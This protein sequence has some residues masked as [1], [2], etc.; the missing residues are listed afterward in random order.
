MP[1]L[2]FNQP[3][4]TA[5]RLAPIG[6]SLD[7]CRSVRAAFGGTVNDVLVAAVAGGVRRLLDARGEC[8]P[9]A[10]VTVMCPVSH[11]EA[12]DAS[13]GNQATGM[14]V[15]VGLDEP[16]PIER[17]RQVRAGTGRAKDVAQAADLAFVVGLTDFVVPVMLRGAV[18]RIRA[19]EGFNLGVSNLAGPPVPVWLL[20]ARVREI[21]PF[22]TIMGNAGMSVTALSYDGTVFVGVNADVA[23]LPDLDVFTAGVEAELADLVAR[24]ATVRPA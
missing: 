13:A 11:R 7:D 15:T 22:G 23:A 14:T 8:G 5:R 21:H 1:R 19:Q 9:G 12:G 2:S 6:L 17:L 3:P 4:G 18:R 24:A 20:G 10:A 16:D